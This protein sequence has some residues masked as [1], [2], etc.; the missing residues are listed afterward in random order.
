MLFFFKPCC[1][2]IMKAGLCN[3]V[4][5][6]QLIFQYISS[7]SHALFFHKRFRNYC[8]SPSSL[9]SQNLQGFITIKD[10]PW[11]CQFHGI[12]GIT[13]MKSRQC[14]VYSHISKL[15][16][17]FPRTRR[18]ISLNGPETT[19][20]TTSIQRQT[21]TLTTRCGASSLLTLVGYWC[22]NTPMS[23]RKGEI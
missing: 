13:S 20:F 12:S 9:E 5:L 6:T 18:M 15:T 14:T 19:G 3:L 11:D 16:S 1:M 2:F 22:A 8:W 17:P 23:S 4:K 7:H 10:L 21:P